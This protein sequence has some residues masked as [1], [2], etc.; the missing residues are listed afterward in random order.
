MAT[1]KTEKVK[2]PEK[3]E[4]EVVSTEI[5]P[6]AQA[7]MEFRLI[8]PTEDGFLRKIQWNR[9]EL[10]EAI[11][12]KVVQYENVVY[13][14]ENIQQAKADRAELN[15]LTKAI[16]DRR[17]MVKS[18]VME[19]YTTFEGEIKEVLELIKKPVEMIDTTIKGYEDQQKEEKKQK[20]TAVYEEV[21]GDL[22]E[23]LPFEKVFDPRYLN[24]TYTLSKAQNEVREKVERVK[25][26][27]DT[28]DSLNSK[29]KLNAKDVYIKTLDLSKAMAENKRLTE[30]EEKLEA[31]KKRKA[32][33]EAERKR[34]E[35]ERR[36]AEEERKAAEEAKEAEAPKVEVPSP[37]APK[38][39]P[40]VQKSEDAA[41]DP[42]ARK[43]EEPKEEPKRYRTRF[44]ALGTKEQLNGLI[45]F[46]KENNIEFG[47]IDK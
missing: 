28:I 15:K 14:D 46:M 9:T 25:T 36:K 3:V 19:P 6:P 32:E 34:L 2:E 22:S 7:E 44:Y 10:E 12:Q 16:E 23:V 43:A 31:D 30:L 8:N 39:Q 18:I 4:G 24:V 26:D 17:K 1:K 41:V 21:I 29:Y 33:E 45:Q 20:I 5:V 13:T 42:F 47:R 37:E 38:E 27:L 35:E 11:K 40:E